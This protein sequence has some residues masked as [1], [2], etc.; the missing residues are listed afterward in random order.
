MAL[1]TVHTSPTYDSFFT[2][3]EMEDFITAVK[4]AHGGAATWD[5]LTDLDK[6]N[7]IKFSVSYINSQPW[8]GTLDPTIIVPFMTWPRVEYIPTP[9]PNAPNEIGYTMACYILKALNGT[10]DTVGP[11]IGAVKKKTVGGVSIEYETGS[12]VASVVEDV[13]TCAEQ[14]SSAYLL[15]APSLSGGIGGVGLRRM[16]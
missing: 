8:L 15:V 1:D 16:P 7:Q 9:P 13:E 10:E 4:Y 3:L 5:L 14:Y 6:E 2:L 12:S 11:A